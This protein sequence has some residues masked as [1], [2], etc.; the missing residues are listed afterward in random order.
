M[1][2]K[3]VFCDLDET[4]I[5]MKSMFS[6][7]DYWFQHWT[8]EQ[9]IDTHGEL[10]DINAIL[11]SLRRR[12]A[13]R[14]ELNRRYYEFFAGRRVSDVAACAERWF[15]HVSQ[16]GPDLWLHD[17]CAEMNRL[18]ALGYEPVLVSGSLTEIARPVA[19]ALAIRHI[20]ATNLMRS[21]DH[22]N[23]RIIAP[24]TIGQGKARAVASFLDRQQARAADCAAMGD[25]RSDIP[26]LELVGDPIAVIG[27]ALL[28]ME[29]SKR[30]WR[31]IESTSIAQAA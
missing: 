12:G 30:G 29:A 28:A 23:G 10:D 13:S 27:D 21:G 2:K 26:M 4:L 17:S 16:I 8:V 15:A 31:R 6:F 3:F 1:T 18:R 22:Y 24:Q 25:D 14:E 5:S 7:Q 20:L 19:D 11:Q 9:G